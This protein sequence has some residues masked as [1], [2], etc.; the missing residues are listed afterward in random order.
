VN[1]ISFS[2]EL[3]KQRNAVRLCVPAELAPAL[4]TARLLPARLT[5][6]GHAVQATLHKMDGSY[7][8]AVNKKVQEQI[9]ATAGDTVTVTIEPDTTEHIIELPDDLASAI[10]AASAMEAFDRLTPFRKRELL[11]AITSAK[12]PETRARR[13]GQA[14]DA[15]TQP[16]G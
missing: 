15:L 9:G 16:D 2:T 13:I 11:T 4:G 10:N 7:M 8:T 5:I 6:N 12:K 1:P 3:V 14:V